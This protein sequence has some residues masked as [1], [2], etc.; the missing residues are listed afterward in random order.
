MNV[1]T[2]SPA[3]ER[4]SLVLLATG[5]LTMIFEIFVRQTPYSPYQLAL[6][7]APFEQLRDTAI[8]LSVFGFLLASRAEGRLPFVLYAVGSLGS[9][10]T[11]A[12]AAALGMNAVQIIDPRPGSSLIFAVRAVFAL[13]VIGVLV[14]ELRRVFR[15]TPKP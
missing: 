1:S 5:V 6:P 15:R 10:L 7:I 2:R 13:L 9:V 11:L 12:V 3:F 8:A 4:L 14:I